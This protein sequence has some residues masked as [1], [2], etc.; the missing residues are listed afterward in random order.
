MI[1]LRFISC[2][3]REAIETTISP[4]DKECESIYNDANTKKSSII[5]NIQEGF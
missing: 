4:N 1:L 2:V 5:N 3:L